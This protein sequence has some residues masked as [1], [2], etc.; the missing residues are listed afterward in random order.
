[1]H[2]GRVEAPGEHGE[3]HMEGNVACTQC[4]ER[5]ALWH[6]LEGLQRR[7]DVNCKGVA[8]I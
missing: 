5:Q 2:G 1:M 3:L 6:V 8:A 4:R 7:Q